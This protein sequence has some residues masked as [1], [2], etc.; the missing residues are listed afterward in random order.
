M[1]HLHSQKAMVQ[2]RSLE[3]AVSRKQ[4]WRPSQQD[5]TQAASQKLSRRATG[6]L[7]HSSRHMVTRWVIGL[8]FWTFLPE[9]WLMSLLHTLT[10]IKSDTWK[11]RLH[12]GARTASLGAASPPALKVYMEKGLYVSGDWLALVVLREKQVPLLPSATPP[13]PIFA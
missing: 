11:V 10:M 4:M 9:G 2:D 7:L 1:P 5:N 13:A 3:P 6:G 12:S 8:Y